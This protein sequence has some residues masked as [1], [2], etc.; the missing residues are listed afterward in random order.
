METS[1]LA[2]N[3]KRLRLEK[4]WSQEKLSREADIPFTT[5]T[6]IENGTTKNPSVETIA[7]IAK[8]LN[9]TLDELIKESKT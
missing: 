6:K 1:K 9:V 2:E 8:A 5:F 7:K 4:D 3:I